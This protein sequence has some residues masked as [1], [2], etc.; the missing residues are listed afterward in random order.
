MDNQEFYLIPKSYF[1]SRKENIQLEILHCQEHQN[2][3]D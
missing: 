2:Y 1:D 3:V